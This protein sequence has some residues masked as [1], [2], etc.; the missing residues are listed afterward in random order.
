MEGVFHVYTGLTLTESTNAVLSGEQ[1][2]LV[3]SLVPKLDAKQARWLST[4]FD[5]FSKGL[6]QVDRDSSN[7][8][9]TIT[10]LFGSETGKA[11]EVA[12]DLRE[13][14]NSAGLNANLCDMA[15]YTVR[16]LATAD[17]IF[18][19]VST[20]GEGDPPQPA[21]T[22]FEFIEGR[23]APKLEQ[24]RFVVLALGD[25][26]YEFFCEAGKRL[27]SRLAD[28]G[29]KRLFDRVDC[30]VD[31]E[32][33]AAISRNTV[34]LF[35]ASETPISQKAV[36][37]V[38]SPA[39]PSVL[40]KPTYSKRIPFPATV[41]EN[42]PIAGRGSS[43]ETRHVELSLDESGLYHEPGDALGIWPDNSPGMVKTLIAELGLVADQ[44][45]NV[46]FGNSRV[47]LCL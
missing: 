12:E 1:W 7:T 43:K 42:I 5:G 44:G 25:S 37:S 2:G 45:I 36:G 18:I 27:D 15:D 3:C 39:I 14:L 34:S 22:F 16:D 38:P 40:N 28:L 35:L 32:Q 17:D 19:V 24:S 11:N 4:Y 8:S 20:Y 21:L 29:A 31:Y 47:H 46:V 23:K 33:S 10:I 6:E 9:R 13:Q 41:I 30:D 26:S